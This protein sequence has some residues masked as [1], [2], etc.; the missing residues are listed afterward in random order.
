LR[1]SRKK[2]KKSTALISQNTALTYEDVDL[3]VRKLAAIFQ[4]QFGIQ[5]GDRIA[6]FLP[7]TIQFIICAQAGLE[8][9]AVMVNINPLYTARELEHVLRDAEP[10]IF[11]YLENFNQ[12]VSEAFQEC[13]DLN[14]TCIA[15]TVG[16]F[17]P[18]WKMWAIYVAQ[19]YIMRSIPKMDPKLYQRSFWLRSLLHSFN[20][21]HAEA[22]DV[23]L[24]TDDLAFLQYT[25]GTTGVP[26][27]AMLSHGNLGANVRQA[28]QWIKKYYAHPENFRIMTA[29]PLY[30]IFSLTANFLAFF[31]L[32]S[33]NVL[34]INPRDMRNF[35][36]DWRRYPV[37][38][39][40]GVNTLFQG[41]LKYPDFKNLDTSRLKIVLGGGMAV[42]QKVADAWQQQTKSVIIQAYGLTE[43]SPGVCINPL[44]LKAFN[45][46]IGLPIDDTEIKF[47]DPDG[48]WIT[49]HEE[50]GELC[51]RG[52]QV[53]KGYWKK[54]DETAETISADGWLHTGDVGYQDEKGFVYLVD[55][56]KDLIII[57]GFKVYPSEIEHVLL[58]HPAIEEA[59]A[60]GETDT[61]GIIS[62]TACCVV[63]KGFECSKSDLE[64][65][66]RHLLTG[67]KIPKTFLFFDQLPKSPV[68]KIVKRELKV[69]LEQRAHPS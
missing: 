8:I 1:D 20:S 68:G 12:V 18:T 46:S 49:N 30:H 50:R 41:L 31:V 52:P 59:A 39:L 32:G 56:Q 28:A 13:P 22:L 55:R 40:C 23:T 37:D 43:A 21:T 53:M 57:S 62:I 35:L 58:Q 42:S 29:L 6:L 17:H 44:D 7:N 67:Y 19:H 51:V 54:P 61:D 14:I 48:K 64:Q 36:K 66:C 24:T 10:K 65:H 16:D 15:T 38:V 69:L 2:Y 4:H 33:E 47:R 63:R 3:H 45:G 27:G 11:I 5:K 34:I 26:K 60:L 25:G 9:G